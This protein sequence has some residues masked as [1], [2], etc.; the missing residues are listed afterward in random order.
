MHEAF[1]LDTTNIHFLLLALMTVAK[2]PVVL[3]P[4]KTPVVLLPLTT[5]DMLQWSKRQ[6]CGQGANTKPS[7]KATQLRKYLVL[8][9]P[10]RH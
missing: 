9:S 3:L 4:L 7:T 1:S 8:S 5:V 2:T 10:Q 6:Q